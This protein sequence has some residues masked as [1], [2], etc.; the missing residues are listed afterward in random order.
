MCT[1]INIAS[2]TN[3][4]FRTSNLLPDLEKKKVQY[5]IS[6]KNTFLLHC[7]FVLKVFNTYTNNLSVAFRS[8]SVGEVG[9]SVLS[10][11]LIT[12]SSFALGKNVQAMKIPGFYS[13][14]EP[15]IDFAQICTL[16]STS[17]RF[18]HFCHSDVGIE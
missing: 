12:I 18:W 13:G 2:Y 15:E 5:G 8:I 10:T 3:L 11:T 16:L 9:N 6:Y 1:N 14:G 7:F 17:S 4:H